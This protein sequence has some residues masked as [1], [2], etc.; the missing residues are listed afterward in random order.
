M[1]RGFSIPMSGVL[2]IVT[3]A[4][5]IAVGVWYNTQSPRPPQTPNEH[6]IAMGV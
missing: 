6:R 1:P 2:C 4:V 5:L 3:G